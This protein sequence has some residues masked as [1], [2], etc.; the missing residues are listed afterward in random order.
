MGFLDHENCYAIPKVANFQQSL[1]D[2][3]LNDDFLAA[4]SRKFELPAFSSREKRSIQLS[5]EGMPMSQQ[6]KKSAPKIYKT[7][8]LTTEKHFQLRNF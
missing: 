5:Y 4:H 2:R 8:V 1:S 6:T 3:K 7:A